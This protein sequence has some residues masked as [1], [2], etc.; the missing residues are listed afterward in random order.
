[1]IQQYAKACEPTLWTGQS[2]AQQEC[3]QLTPM[4]RVY[5]K[6]STPLKNKLHGEEVLGKPS[7]AVVRSLKRSLKNLEKE[8]EVLETALLNNVKKEY[9]E[10]LTLLK[11]IP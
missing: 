1:M 8:I 7:R 9:Q 10:S 2:K 3:L 5:S 4:L 6:Q 11:S